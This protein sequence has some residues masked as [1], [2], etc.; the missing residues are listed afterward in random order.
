M[1]RESPLKLTDPAI[2]PSSKQER[3]TR[4]LYARL[5]YQ[6]LF[7]L[8]N[9]RYRFPYCFQENRIDRASCFIT[10]HATSDDLFACALSLLSEDRTPR[11][12][13]E[14]ILKARF[15]VGVD[16]CKTAMKGYIVL[17]KE[18]INI[19][20]SAIV[21]TNTNGNDHVTQPGTHAVGKPRFET[22]GVDEQ[23]LRT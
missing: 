10:L 7:Q 23:E 6:K 18:I 4:R 14:S 11:E 17:A 19:A 3:P 1:R 15:G 21:P 12:S 13:I 8:L 2:N 5:D 9:S 22:V 16:E 20:R